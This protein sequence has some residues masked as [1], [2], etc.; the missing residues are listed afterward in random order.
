MALRFLRVARLCRIR[1]VERLLAVGA[2]VRDI[3]GLIHVLQAERG[4]SSI[5]LGS[6]GKRFAT[7]R[8]GRVAEALAL[9]AVLRDRLDHLDEQ[10]DRMSSGARFYGRVAGALQALDRLPALRDQ[11]ASLALV[12]QDSVKAFT[13]VIGHLLAVLV[14]AA[15]IAADP[16]ISRALV[17]LFNIVQGKEF[18]GQERATAGAGFSRGRFD[19]ADHARLIQLIDA[20]NRAFRIFSEFAD[21]AHTAAF[22]AALSDPAVTEVERMRAVALA[23]GARHGELSGIAPEA[24]FEQATRRMDR[25]KTVED[26]LTG[27]LRLLCEAKLAQARADLEQ[28][29]LEQAALHSPDAAMPVAMMLVDAGSPL[30]GG[31]SLPGQEDAGLF[32][33]DGLPPRL[34][35]SVLDVVQA[36]SQRL[37]DVSLELETAKAALNERK[38]IDRAKGLLMSTRNLSEEE[39]YKLIRKTAMNQNKRIIEV[40]EAILSMSDI[41]R[42]V[43]TGGG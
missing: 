23:D 31:P 11:V 9:E 22:R 28:T 1:D 42:G 14:E 19:G 3:G 41:L 27:D 33:P 24:W 13:D 5:Y 8:A 40:A 7:D 10:L 36:Q 34:M 18:A 6:C 20:Q 26:R 4:A 30:P 39:A 32:A 15:D 29:D 38:V 17:A 2:L 43:T 25:M 21:P 12:P 35:R 37:R 16:A